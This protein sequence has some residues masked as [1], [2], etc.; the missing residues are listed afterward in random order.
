[1]R[2]FAMPHHGDDRAEGPADP[3]PLPRPLPGR[4]TARGYGAGPGPGEAHG[5]GSGL[6]DGPGNAHGTGSGAA[7]RHRTGDAPEAGETG[8]GTGSA[9]GA[10]GAADASGGAD[11]PGTAD[12]SRGAHE[13]R[14]AHGQG[15]AHEQSAAHEQ[16]A[17]EENA[18][19]EQRP[20]HDQGPAPAPRAPFAPP[21]F[22]GPPGQADGTPRAPRAAPPSPLS[23]F[24][25]TLRT[26]GLDPDAEQLG[27]ALWLAGRIGGPPGED[28]TGERGAPE[29]DVP[30]APP[31]PGPVPPAPPTP[32]EEPPSHEVGRTGGT[33]GLY[34]GRTGPADGS[35]A[36]VGPAEG[37]AYAVGD[38]APGRGLR[39]GVPAAPAFGS[40]LDLQ[41]ALRPLQRFRT[42][43]TRRRKVLDETATAELSARAGGLVLPVYRTVER[44]EATLHLVL[45]ASPSMRVWERMFEE[46]RQVFSQLGAFAGIR[47]HYLHEGP[48]PGTP[49][50]LAAAPGAGPRYAP[51]RLADPT[52]R[53]LTLVVSDCAGELW[54]T[55]Q[56]HRLLH[57]LAR[58]GP[59]SV[60]QPL[61]QRLWNRTRLPVVFGRLTRTGTGRL[62]V[63]EGTTRPSPEALPVPVVPP[64]PAALASWARLMTGR[65][66][67]AVTGA[68]GW[69]RPDQP[70]G[71]APERSAEVPALQRVSRFRA[72]A[73]PLAGRLATHLAAAPL[74]LPVMQ[75]V[76]RTMLPGSGPAEL[77]EVLLGG[78]LRQ[79]DED[80]ATGPW[81]AFAPGV[82]EALLGPLGRD[83]AAL[84][85]KH[86]SEYVT[87]HFGKGGPNFPALAL[88]QLD[89]G[90][91]LPPPAE[92]DRLPVT[93]GEGYEDA[94]DAPYE[95]P[96]GAG[97]EE[98]SAARG[99]EGVPQP[100]AEVAAEVLRRFLPVSPLPAGDG[101][102]PHPAL[103]AADG[104]VAE[105]ERHGMVQSL[106]D[107]AQLL[108]SAVR[109]QQQ[110]AP[111]L[112]A[113]CAATLLRL[114]RVERGEAMLQEA[115]GHAEAAVAAS[116]A[117][118]HRAVLAQVLAALA[119]DARRQGSRAEALDLLRAAEREYAA[120]CAAPGLDPAHALRLTLERV[121]VLESQFRIS[122][123]SSLL[124]S[125][126]G[127]LE[128][129][130]DAREGE[131]NEVPALLALAHGRLLL[132]LAGLAGA[133]ADARVRARRA[134]HSLRTALDV[135]P[136]A[137][138][139]SALRPEDRP[140]VVLDLVDALLASGPEGLA[141]AARRLVTALPGARARHRSEL[142]ARTARLH[143]A[144]YT[145][146]A[147]PAELDA[148]AE[149]FDQ[150]LPGIPRDSAAHTRLLA[151]YGQTLLDRARLGDGDPA[152]RLARA[153]RAVQVLRTC[154]TE[155]GSRHSA[156]PHRELLLGRAL[157]HRHHLTGDRVDLREAEFHLGLAARRTRESL[158]AATAHLEW[159]QCLLRA[160]TGASRLA[161]YGEAADVFR[162]AARAGRRAQEEATTDRERAT[163]VSRTAQAHHWLGRDYAGAAQ[164]RAAR[165]A[166][167]AALEEW[168]RLPTGMEAMGEPTPR[169]TAQE[170]EDLANRPAN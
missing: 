7:G 147:D 148:A 1:M 84:I 23:S 72:A 101:G 144:R 162:A 39:I 155:T 53:S 109:Q 59:V 54:R 37:S 18:A 157:V 133:G 141:E 158:P 78:L 130:A 15:A 76:Q 41:R 43:G 106:M 25:L 2:D 62:Q 28:G 19:H 68:I 60:L 61:P 94:A 131:E 81:Y 88:A 91:A 3:G 82:R 71:A 134:A 38:L 90:P 163:A 161:R 89:G 169:Q 154:L 65:G 73:S 123:D 75:L 151:E 108:R 33:V 27:D 168:K 150:A 115:R 149:H 152:A 66:G 67:G 127:M 35:G 10:P 128:A 46:L 160:A 166:Y 13:Q 99:P 165:T 31:P 85:L 24:V 44:R 100:F 74:S 12:A 57:R 96:D 87:Q 86:C 120:A 136:P 6:E 30:P 137:H 26:A 29:S 138:D 14:A 117:P 45:D 153:T 145:E 95:G 140:A 97:D 116:H 58:S 105:Y 63:A 104:L 114:W 156:A 142:L 34:A 111:E 17:H 11:A 55:G 112:L 170:L 83:E 50:A 129:L 40:T 159:G 77:A 4:G 64:V 92:R 20:A 103:G 121:G 51:E 22:A 42:A 135:T 124:Q 119:E 16:G 56:G 118:A 107:A 52:G 122:G 69:V 48:G 113:T 9:A 36:R 143:R 47:C 132:R 32:P 98:E 110:P 80:P 146:N 93:G 126:V 49:L 70:A 164:P 21:G 125:G 5:A 167:L 139:E 102:L 8:W 79:S